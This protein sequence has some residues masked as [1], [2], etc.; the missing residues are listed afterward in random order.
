LDIAGLYCNKKIV[1]LLKKKGAIDTGGVDYWAIRGANLQNW[2]GK[3]PLDK[4]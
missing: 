3:V 2:S 4:K 1:D